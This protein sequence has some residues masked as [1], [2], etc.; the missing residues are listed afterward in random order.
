MMLG[1]GSGL[2]VMMRT[3]G[4]STSRVAMSRFE[5][6]MSPQAHVLKAWSTAGDT[7][8]GGVET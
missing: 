2:M 3:N 7:V 5:Y 1:G 4:T 8:L 6:E